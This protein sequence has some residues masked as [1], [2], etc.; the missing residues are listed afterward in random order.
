MRALSIPPLAK[1]SSLAPVVLR[2][3]V[4]VV[5]AAHGLQKLQGG[6]AE[7]FGQGMLGGM[8]GLPAPELL[9]WL[10]TIAELVGGILLIFGLLT[11]LATIPLIAVLLG[12][13]A[14]VKADMGL[15]VDDGAGAELDLALLAGLVAVLLLGPGR[16]SLDHLLGIERGVPGDTAPDSPAPLGADTATAGRR[17]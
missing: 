2:V 4:G 16:P 12:A 10:V 1:L 8:L 6:P 14:L 17:A 15:I 11:R 3:A 9:G 5:M 13:I 7:G